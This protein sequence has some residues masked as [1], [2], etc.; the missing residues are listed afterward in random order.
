MKEMQVL[1]TVPFMM[2]PPWQAVH[3]VAEHSA[4]PLKSEKQD[5]QVNEAVRYDPTIHFK[6]LVA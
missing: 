1:Q 4:Q 5:W 3:A 2:Y 6:Q